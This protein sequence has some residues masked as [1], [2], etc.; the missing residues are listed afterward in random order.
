MTIQPA[1]KKD[2]KGLRFSRQAREREQDRKAPR[3]G[4]PLLWG[5]YYPLSTYVTS[6]D[7]IYINSINRSLQQV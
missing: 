2:L 7:S 3:Q 5:R 6:I 4:E 1:I